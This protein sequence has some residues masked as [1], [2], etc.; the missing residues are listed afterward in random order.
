L[1]TL[2]SPNIIP[3]RPMMAEL[4]SSTML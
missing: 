2:P 4:G 3:M 1:A